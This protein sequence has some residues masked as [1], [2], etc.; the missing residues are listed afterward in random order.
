MAQN[1]IEKNVMLCKCLIT[2]QIKYVLKSTQKNSA[3]NYYKNEE[4]L[5][6]VLS[7]TECPQVWDG[8]E[9]GSSTPVRKETRWAPATQHL[10]TL[11]SVWVWD[12]GWTRP[13]V[14]TSEG[15][16]EGC[17]IPPCSIADLPVPPGHCGRIPDEGT[18]GDTWDFPSPPNRGSD[19]SSL[20]LLA[21]E[22]QC[23]EALALEKGT[24]SPK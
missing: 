6:S 20:P 14:E 24:T 9:G 22:V 11:I 1:S 3:L 13:P 12:S 7:G 21:S 15:L 23:G 18:V 16:T 5:N 8:T 19:S 4:S 2:K 10:H 17:R